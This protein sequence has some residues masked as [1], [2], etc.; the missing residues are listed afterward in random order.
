[1][2]NTTSQQMTSSERAAFLE[3]AKIKG[4]LETCR[5][6]GLTNATPTHGLNATNKVVL[7]HSRAATRN[8]RTA[9]KFL[10]CVVKTTIRARLR[11]SRPM[12]TVEMDIKFV[13]IHGE[14]RAMAAMAGVS[15][16]LV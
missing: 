7:R 10:R 12:E 1:M 11:P 6:Y 8:P 14:Q 2:P 16:N 3:E 4:V 13:Y 9:R 15:D 5:I